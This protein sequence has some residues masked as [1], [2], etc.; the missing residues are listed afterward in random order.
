MIIFSEL[1]E[2]LELSHLRSIEDENRKE[3]ALTDEQ[4]RRLFELTLLN[5]ERIDKVELAYRKKMA[6]WIKEPEYLDERFAQ[7]NALKEEMQNSI[8]SGRAMIRK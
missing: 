7:I 1:K 8:D 3:S 6:G 2:Y 5:N 4:R